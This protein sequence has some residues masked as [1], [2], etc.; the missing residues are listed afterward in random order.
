[1]R[2]CVLVRVRM[3]V[4]SHIIIAVFL[5]FVCLLSH[6]FFPSGGLK[7]GFVLIDLEAR[8]HQGCNTHFEGAPI[9]YQSSPIWRARRQCRY[10][11]SL[12][13]ALSPPLK[14]T[15]A[16]PSPPP[17]PAA[18]QP[19][20]ALWCANTLRTPSM[21]TLS[22]VPLREQNNVGGESCR[23]SLCKHIEIRMILHSVFRLIAGGFLID[24]VALCAKSVGL[25]LSK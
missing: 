23:V 19:S 15:S 13:S 21:L 12:Y 3:C 4:N 17:T 10:I 2:E 5:F 18:T 1:M 16:P 6:F 14:E 11:T 9:A 24:M 8:G 25:T 20:L 22:S 7:R